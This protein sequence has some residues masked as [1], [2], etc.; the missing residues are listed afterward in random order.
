MAIN[1]S[2]TPMSPPGPYDSGERE[3]G[4]VVA[5]LRVHSSQPTSSGLSPPP[6]AVRSDIASVVPPSSFNK[7]DASG[8]PSWADVS[9]FSSSRSRAALCSAKNALPVPKREDICVL[10]TEVIQPSSDG[11]GTLPPPRLDPFR[12]RLSLCDAFSLSLRDFPNV[13]HTK[14]G[15]ALHLSNR[16][17]QHK[18]LENK[19]EVARLGGARQVTIPTTWHTEAV[20]NVASSLQG[21]LGERT[22][23]C[24]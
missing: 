2:A 24:G 19:T 14:T 18:L 8:T 16:A 12:L 13:T 15:Y 3:H 17:I 9:R 20:P 6:A 4:E 23:D 5:P 22:E 7:Y 21:I 1:F 10:V 11:Q